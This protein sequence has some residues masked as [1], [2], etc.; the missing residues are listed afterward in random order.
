MGDSSTMGATVLRQGPRDASHL[1]ALSVVSLPDYMLGTLAEF[2]AL[3]GYVSLG[4][5]ARAGPG[6]DGRG[7]DHEVRM[8]RNR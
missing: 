3:L 8:A 2:P 7:P 4:S 6:L 1:L 5:S